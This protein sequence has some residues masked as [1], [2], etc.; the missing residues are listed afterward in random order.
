MASTLEWNNKQNSFGYYFLIIK[1]YLIIYYHLKLYLR[2][3]CYFL[4][5]FMYQSIKNSIDYF[6]GEYLYD[7]REY[8]HAE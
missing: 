3:N 1:I 5:C 6:Y 8:K 2:N 4:L 7:E